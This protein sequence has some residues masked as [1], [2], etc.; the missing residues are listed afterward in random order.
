M[1]L[2]PIVE[3]RAVVLSEKVLP[4]QPDWHDG[5]AEFFANLDVSVRYRLLRLRRM[6]PGPGHVEHCFGPGLLDCF[7]EQ[8]H[9]LR[10]ALGILHGQGALLLQHNVIV[11]A[12]RDGFGSSTGI[13]VSSQ[14]SST[15][16]D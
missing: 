8:A 13:P 12:S 1:A 5:R 3:H 2:V 10:H 14:G 4:D 16:A 9:V 15:H 11:A 6:L 7:I